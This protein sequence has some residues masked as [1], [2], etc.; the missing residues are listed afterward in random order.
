MRLIASALPLAF[1]LAA[2]LPAQAQP[3]P[4]L[5]DAANEGTVSVSGH[6]E[7]M[8]KPDTAMVTS[9]V[10]SQAATAREALD[11]NTRDMTALL[12]AMKAAG[13]EAKD[14]QTSNFTVSP[15]YV[16]TDQRDS[17][18]YTQPP[19]IDGYVVSNQVTVR[20]R[21]LAILGQVLDQSVTVGANTISGVSFSVDNPA[22]L[23]NQARR[24]AFGDAR[25]KA[26][27]YAGE[28]QDA[29][30]TVISINEAPGFLQPQPMMRQAAEAY[31]AAPAPVPVAAGELSFAVDVQVTWALD[32]DAAAQSQ[33]SSQAPR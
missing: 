12:D 18:G 8:A 23:Y 19:R 9:G 26:T 6:G 10:T 30:G 32:G 3:A 11:A 2:A 4:G 22:E 27:L 7:I 14:I 29:I 15:N 21:D 13:I 25:E 1:I 17:S 20:V 31:A 16:Y 24:A 5:P 28:S 33:G